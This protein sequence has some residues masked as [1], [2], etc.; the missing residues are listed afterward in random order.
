LRIANPQR[1][2]VKYAKLLFNIAQWKL[3]QMDM[4]KHEPNLVSEDTDLT[5]DRLKLVKIMA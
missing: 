3:V 1:A 5:A 4:R 2:C